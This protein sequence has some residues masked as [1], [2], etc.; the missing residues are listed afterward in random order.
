MVFGIVHAT[1]LC[2][3]AEVRRYVV[4][5]NVGPIYPNICRSEN[6]G[7]YVFTVTHPNSMRMDSETERGREMFLDQVVDPLVQALPTQG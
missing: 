4:V 2:T 5:L 7:I 6:I 1:N 3:R